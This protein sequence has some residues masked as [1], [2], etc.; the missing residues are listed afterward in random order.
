MASRTSTGEVQRR[1]ARCGKVVARAKRKRKKRENCACK[2]FAS[3]SLLQNFQTLLLVPFL[4]T[5]L[6]KGGAET[7]ACRMPMSIRGGGH[8][9][10]RQNAHGQELVTNNKRISNKKP[11]ATMKTRSIQN[12]TLVHARSWVAANTPHIHAQACQT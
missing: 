7:L 2:L 6:L 5:G 12:Y 11:R 8:G 9:V 3:L 10:L 4:A 1:A